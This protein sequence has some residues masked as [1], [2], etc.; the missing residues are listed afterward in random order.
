LNPLD[1]SAPRFSRRLCGIGHY[2][3]SAKPAAIVVVGILTAA[4][5]LIVVLRMHDARGQ[6]NRR[7]SLP[8]R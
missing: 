3:P 6:P 5:G 1:L 8:T 2:P 4:S 7:A